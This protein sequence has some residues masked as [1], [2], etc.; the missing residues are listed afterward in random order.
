MNPLSAVLVSLYF[1]VLAG[2]FTFGIHRLVMVVL[3]A[4]SKRQ[5]AAAALPPRRFAAGELPL[6]TIQLPIFNE[7]TVTE[8]LLDAASHIEYP[9]DRLE[10]QVLDDSTDETRHIA[11]TKVASLRARG[12]DIHYIRRPSRHGYKAGALDY[13]LKLARGELIAMFDADFV[14]EPTFLKDIVDHF[15]DPEV[16][17][18]QTRW[19]HM[20]RSVN[21]MTEVQALMLDG[22]HLIE[23][24]A[25]FGSGCFFNFAGTG[26]MWRREAIERAGGWQ[27]DTIT[28]DLD[29]SYRAQMAGYRFIYRPDVLTPA[30]LP[31]DMSALRQQQHR[32]AKGTVQT[33]RKL[34]P[35]V[36]EHEPLSLHQKVEASF[37]ML[38][39]FAYPLMLLLGL[40]QLPTLLLLE[41]T[42]LKTMLMVDL[43][44]CLLATGS[45]ATFY[46][47][48]ETRQ[49][50]SV[51]GALKRLPVLIALGAG[52]SPY[53]TRAV[54]A[55]M[56]Q[57]SGEFVR[58]PKKGDGL[59]RY[60]M[61]AQL[62]VAEIGLGLLSLVAALV[63]V[64]TGHWFAAPFCGLFAWGYLYV[65]TMLVKEQVLSSLGA[66]ETLETPLEAA[67]EPALAKAA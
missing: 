8:R 26:G 22:H 15:T 7:A 42:D 54:F 9:R 5:V 45:I 16:G 48:A 38:P 53:L 65:A 10:I 62:P 29:L 19:A 6:V 32:W 47:Y 28:E 23:D 2:L 37:H 67:Q 21:L 52:L 41:A 25:R 17:M 4:R 59:S 51:W 66:G 50:R 13:G 56:S 1:L 60:R 20:N 61:G 44:M 43:P 18:V 24:C 30:E 35:T 46:A 33:A 12:L 58:T 40:L 63:A 11:E 57:M 34:L 64:D 14:P 39:H 55:G 31:E 3:A 49:D 27:H 36:W